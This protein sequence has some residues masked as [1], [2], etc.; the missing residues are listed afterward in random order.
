MDARS[1][2]ET[3]TSLV[4]GASYEPGASVDFATVYVP[5]D[6]LV[7]TCQ[8][9]LGTGAN[10]FVFDYRGYGKSQGRPS[11]EGTYLDAQAAHAWLVQKGIAPDQIVAFGES[12]GG[13][14]FRVTARRETP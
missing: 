6:R 14:V 4:P 1:I 5:A 13:G 9:L 2:V 8:A 7:D 10:V 11:E 3:L 12:L